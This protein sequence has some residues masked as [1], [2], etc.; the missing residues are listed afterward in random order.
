[1]L[2]PFPSLDSSGSILRHF[3]LLVP[4]PPSVAPPFLSWG[5]SNAFDSPGVPCAP[6]SPAVRLS[7]LWWD[8]LV[9]SVLLSPPPL[10]LLSSFS[11][12][13]PH[14]LLLKCFCLTETLLS[15][16]REKSHPPVLAPFHLVSCVYLLPHYVF[17]FSSLCYSHAFRLSIGH[18]FWMIQSALSLSLSP[19][20][21]FFSWLLPSVGLCHSRFSSL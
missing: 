13:V 9:P 4:L 8:H 10:F 19:P 12:P 14:S 3:P 17:F 20:P 15:P 6:G 21:F 16:F 5:L 18:R 2:P 1:L 11:P 7:F